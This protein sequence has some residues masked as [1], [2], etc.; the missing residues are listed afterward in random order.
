MKIKYSHFVGQKYTG[1]E[2][3][4]TLYPVVERGIITALVEGDEVDGERLVFAQG[5]PGNL[6]PI[7]NTEAEN[8]GADAVI[9]GQ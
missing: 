8:F 6:Y 2:E 7:T 1:A 3:M 5:C 9:R 4:E